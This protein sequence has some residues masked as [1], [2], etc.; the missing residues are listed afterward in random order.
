MEAAAVFVDVPVCPIERVAGDA[1]VS[2]ESDESWPAG[3]LVDGGAGQV[4]FFAVEV[5]F[6][7]LAILD[8]CQGNVD[9]SCSGPAV[10]SLSS[11]I[12]GISSASGFAPVVLRNSCQGS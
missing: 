8:F 10:G 9:A 6:R 12:G 3:S 7:R 5:C 1:D 2:I 4:H 11:S